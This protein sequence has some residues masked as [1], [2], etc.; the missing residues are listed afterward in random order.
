[1][2][3][4]FVSVLLT[5][6]SISSLLVQDQSNAAPEQKPGT[7]AVSSEESQAEALR[8]AAQNPVA[9]LISVVLQNNANFSYG[10]FNRTQDVLELS[11]SCRS[12][13]ATTGI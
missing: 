2:R 12:S 5:L 4:A 13:S 10:S 3:T 6:L 11:L 1:M 7:S 9:N 8:K